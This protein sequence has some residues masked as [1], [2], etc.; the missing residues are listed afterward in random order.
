MAPIKSLPVRAR[1]LT[2]ELKRLRET[3]GLSVEQAAAQLNWS[4][5]K[6]N[7][8]ELG[9]AIPE[10]K[11]VGQILRLYGVEGERHESLVQLAREAH[12]RGWWETLGV[13]TGSYVGLEDEASHLRLWR[14]LLVPGLLQTE[15]YSRALIE[16]ALTKR[17]PAEVE[18]RVRARIARQTLLG[19]PDAPQFHAVIGEAVLRHETGGREVLHEQ[20]RKILDVISK[21]PNVTVQVLPFSAGASVGLEGAFTHLEFPEP[22]DPDVSYIED[23]S[24]EQYVESADGNRRF[25]LAHDRIA[26]Q[27]LSTEASAELIADILKESNSP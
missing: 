12:E 7:R 2:S 19:R 6:L 23:L 22:I 14:P 1:R 26:G 17:S 5:S 9:R 18:K 11:V 20:L 13:F 10:P 16:A 15:D 24:G 4:Y 27:A 25:R 3:A 21:R 8:F